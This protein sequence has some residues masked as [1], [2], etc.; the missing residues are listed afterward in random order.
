MNTIITIGF[1]GIKR[2]Y[3]NISLDEAKE[4]YSKVEGFSIEDIDKGI[5]DIIEFEDEFGVYD[6]WEI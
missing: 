5:I 4:R 1:I 6:I 3:L 2:G